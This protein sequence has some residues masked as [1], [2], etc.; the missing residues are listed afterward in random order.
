MTYSVCWSDNS[1]II[2]HLCK[3]SEY[4][5]TVVLSVQSEQYSEVIHFHYTIKDQVVLRTV[6]VFYDIVAYITVSL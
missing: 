5:S 6:Y 3:V 1:P 4:I 2:L